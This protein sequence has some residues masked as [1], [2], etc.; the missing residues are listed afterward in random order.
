[1]AQLMTNDERGFYKSQK[2]LAEEQIKSSKKQVR[3]NRIVS[4]ITLTLSLLTL[5]ILFFQLRILESTSQ[6][7]SPK[8]EYR[9]LNPEHDSIHYI[10]EIKGIYPPEEN[11]TGKPIKKKMEE[12]TLY[13]VNY[14]KTSTGTINLDVGSYDKELRMS[15]DSISLESE[16]SMFNDIRFWADNC[17]GGDID[18]LEA[19]E[20][21]EN[22]K[23]EPGIKEI[24]IKIKAN[25]EEPKCYS[26]KMCLANFTLEAN[27]YCE[28]NFNKEDFE[29]TPVK[30]PEDLF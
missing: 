17:F 16:D 20:E 15:T 4:I 5:I 11:S 25:Y 8:V 28:L 13:A 1:M 9:L 14:G 2:K 7:L 18:Y 10:S 21:C 22:S 6:P 23:L 3:W 29:L 27:R 19:K 12:F 30:C 26:F 24:F